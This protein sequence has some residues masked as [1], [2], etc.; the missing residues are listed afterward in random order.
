MAYR[1]FFS[2]MKMQIHLPLDPA[3]LLLEMYKTTTPGRCD[4]YMKL[5]TRALFVIASEWTQV[6]IIKNWLPMIYYVYCKKE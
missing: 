5:F 6:P 4:V 1:E 3:T 2:I